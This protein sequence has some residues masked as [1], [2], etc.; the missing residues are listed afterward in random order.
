MVV[1]GDPGCVAG[2][3]RK[4]RWRGTARRFPILNTVPA[5][6]PSHMIP[7]VYAM[8]YA[9]GLT[10]ASTP[11]EPTSLRLDDRIRMPSVPWVIHMF[12]PSNAI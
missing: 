4:E 6:V 8:P 11:N 7:P 12:V 2:G 5:P 10:P 9:A 1:P 3:V